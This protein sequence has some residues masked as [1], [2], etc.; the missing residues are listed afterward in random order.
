MITI[1]LLGITYQALFTILDQRRYRVPPGKLVDV[2]GYKLHVQVMGATKENSPTVIMDAGVGNNSLDWQLVQPE[3]AQRARVI[4]YDRAG[5]GWSDDGTEPRT[6]ERVVEELHQLLQRA[7]I[8]P[9]YLMV[10]HSFG[11]IY[12]RLFA[13]QYPDEVVGLVLVESSHPDMIKTINT[14]PELK[15]LRRVAVFKKFGIVRA[16]LPRLL[17][18]ANYLDPVARKQYLAMNMLDSDNVIREALPMYETG[19]TLSDSIDLPVTV[20]SRERFDEVAAEQRW[21]EYQDQLAAL[22][23]RVRHLYSKSSSHY[24]ALAD[25]QIVISAVDDLLAL[26]AE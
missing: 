24:T 3:I 15:R 12:V 26:L 16:M 17:S 19:I 9:P 14:G 7:E 5:Y 6:P 23:P 2:G 21:Q 25:P 13:E 1:V 22:S 4:S 10:G 11:G 20:I 18:H 8:E